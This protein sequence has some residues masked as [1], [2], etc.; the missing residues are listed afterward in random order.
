LD[1]IV[2]YELSPILWKKVKVGLSAGRVQ[3]ATL[4]IIV[5]REKERIAFK[6]VEFCDLKAVSPL[7]FEALLISYDSKKIAKA[8][9]FDSDGKLQES[10]SKGDKEQLIHLDLKQAEKL[11]EKLK[12]AEFTVG[13][14]DEKPFTRKPLAPFTTSTLQQS[15]SNVLGLSAYRTMRDAQ[16][17]YENGYITYMRTDSP[18]LSSQAIKSARENVEKQFGKQ[19]LDE[20]PRVYASKT[21]HS[22]EAHEAIR[23]AGSSF[24]H[25]SKLVDKLTS[26]Q[27]KLYSMIYERTLASQMK[28]Q[29]GLTTSIHLNA[30]TKNGETGVFSFSGT[31]ILFDGWTRAISSYVSSERIL[32]A[33]KVGMKI[34]ID[35]V[36]VVEHSTKPP[37]RYTEASIIKKMEELGIGRPSTY[38]SIINLLYERGYVK[39]ISSA[40]VPNW[41]AFPVITLLKN[42]FSSLVN[43]NFTAQMEDELDEI[44]YGR[45]NEQKW[46][47][48]FYFGEN[49]DSS[50][51]LKNKIETMP[52]IDTRDLNTIEIS[53]DISLHIGKYGT[54]IQQGEKKM[55][56][57]D[58]ILPD[59]LD[60]DAAK[61]ILDS[62]SENEERE[63]GTDESG[64][65]I[66]A[67]TGRFGPYVSKIPPEGSKEKVKNASLF[68]SMNVETINLATA[69]KLLSLPR[70]V[71]KNPENETEIIA[72]NGK[73]GPYIKCGTDSRTLETQEQLFEITVEQAVELLK[74]PKKSRSSAGKSLGKDESGKTISVKSGRF[75]PYVTNG[76]INASLPKGIDSDELTL[77][78]AIELL[79]KKQNSSK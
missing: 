55:S 23:P 77:E 31:Q 7:G 17:L 32:P 59:Q 33:L 76:K 52:N 69:E 36:S 22:Q 26:T 60:E 29:E 49:S 20:K 15:A 28:N 35:D 48:D 41:I 65:T 67:K 16:V 73:Y 74:Q 66:V 56:V 11:A 13:S 9:D 14:V 42:N 63:L 62:Y 10:G 37:A 68:K 8:K 18:A 43:S 78:T 75:G 71:G 61:Q 38:A 45:I 70:T 25:P 39:K 6:S 51:G 58:D 30:E 1:R 34:D 12:T 44:A 24:I 40:I 54:Y 21:E 2:G 4:S 72:A 53:K 79:L 19:Y 57:P 50:T 64:N 27:A 3:S 47:H 5:D 46:L